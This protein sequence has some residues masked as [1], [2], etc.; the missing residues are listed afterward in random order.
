MVGEKTF[1][2]GVGQRDFPLVN[3]GTLRLVTFEWLTPDKTNLQKRG[4]SPDLEVADSR[5]VEPWFLQ[6]EGAM[7]GSEVVLSV[8]DKTYNLLADGNGRFLL[9]QSQGAD[10][11]Q[12][13][14]QAISLLQASARESGSH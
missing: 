7:P 14:A 11:D 10:G 1:G 13:L 4:I 9:R 8:G 6:G 5:L 2:K 12:I 3:G